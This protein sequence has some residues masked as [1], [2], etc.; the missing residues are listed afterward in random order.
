[1]T[2]AELH[3]ALRGRGLHPGGRRR[4]APRRPPA[5]SPASPTT[6][7]RSSPATC[8]SRS[9]ACT[10]TARRSRSRRSSAA[11]PPSCRSRRRRR[12]SSVPWA[13][14]EDARLAL[15][16]LADDV[17]SR[18]RAA[19]CR[20]SASPA[21]T[22]RRRR[23]TSS[24]SIFEAAGIRCGML[25]TVGYR[26]GGRACARRRARRRRRRRCR[27]CCARWSIAAA[28]RARW[29]CRRTRCRCAAS[30]AC[31]FAAGVFTN[32]TRDHLDFHARHGDVLPGQ[33]AAVRDAAARRA[34]PDQPGRS[35][36]RRRC[37]T[38]A[39][40]PVTYAINRPADITPGP[41]SFSLDGLAFD[42]RTPR[43]TLHVRSTL[44]GRP[45][46]YNILAAVST[47]DGARP[48]RS[49]R[50]SAGIAV[51]RRRARAV[52]GRVRRRRTKSPSSSTT[53][54]PTM[55][56]ATC[57]RRRGRSRAAG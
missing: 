6:P 28:A 18:I 33:A 12:T 9:R 56:C 49:T 42:V 21:P 17:L 46:V 2:W 23:R 34:E 52:P 40:G 16:L 39:G 14:V 38:P 55:R 5:W 26:I 50:S 54:T 57:S 31:S 7:A 3:G 45:N 30:T 41:L 19:R 15:A 13:I 48:A 20:S 8:S 51:A 43:G 44:V 22:A 35:A 24:P 25:G 1:M 47:G 53:R 36:R 29:R 32:L 10:R 11:P 27:R 37:S 4:C